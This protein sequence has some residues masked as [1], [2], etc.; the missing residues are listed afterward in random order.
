MEAGTATGISCV[1]IHVFGASSAVG[2]AVVQLALGNGHPVLGYSRGRPALPDSAS[3]W[4]ACDLD[5]PDAHKGFD[6]HPTDVLISAAPLRKVVPVLERVSHMRPSRVVAISSASAVTKKLS[7]WSFDR[8]LSE[9]LRQCEARLLSQL[10]AAATVLRPTMIYGSGRD[11]NV[12]RLAVW[13]RRWRCVP[14]LASSSGMRAPIHIDDL[15]AVAIRVAETGFGS[16]A[17][18]HVPGG[19]RVSYRLMLDRISKGCGVAVALPRIPC[20]PGLMMAVG[21]MMPKSAAKLFAAASRMGEDLTVPDD[22]EALGVQRRAF[23]PDPR[24]LGLRSADHS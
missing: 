19:E 18:L 23:H 7:A 17:I 9:E 10:G 22:V 1:R 11:R 24:A 3:W 5:D 2:C 13:M 12:A 8:A 16:G 4:Q 15:A 21:A 20:S 6:I 14:I